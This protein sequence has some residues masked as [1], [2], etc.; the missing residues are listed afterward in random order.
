MANLI[1]PPYTQEEHNLDLVSQEVHD[2]LSASLWTA[3]LLDPLRCDARFLPVLANF[4][5]VDFWSD[6]LSEA[7]K[8]RLIASS[9]DIKR[10]KGTRWAV[11]LAVNSIGL[12]PTITE[13][14][15]TT[16]MDVHT[17]KIVVDVPD[18]G[19]D[20]RDLSLVEQVVFPVKPVR[21]HL[22]S[23]G[24]AVSRSENTPYMAMVVIGSETTTLYPEA[25]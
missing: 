6:A 8:R 7:D 4:Y 13:W 25:V 19:Y 17:F 5:S 14:H 2:R 1:P 22:T 18:V 20:M 23:V 10:H 24:A 3:P 11:N 16:G 21:S 15:Q 12:T 9:I